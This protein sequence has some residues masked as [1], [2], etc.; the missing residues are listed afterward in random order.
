[1][2]QA[3]TLVFLGFGF[4]DQNMLVLSE[5]APKEE[6]RSSIKRVLATVCGLSASDTKVVTQQIARTL[7]GRPL[8]ERDNYTVDTFN[9]TCSEFFEEYW[10]SLTA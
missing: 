3:E 9:G 7:K 5:D 6:K 8:R 1:M 10:R 4:H 2:Q